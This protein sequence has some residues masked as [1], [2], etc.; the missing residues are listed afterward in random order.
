MIETVF[1]DDVSK[2]S[3][4]QVIKELRES[5]IRVKYSSL[6]R[7]F[8]K[9]AAIFAG[10]EK[11]LGEYVVI[12]DADLQDHPSL[13]IDMFKA[14]TVEGYDSAATRRINRYGEPKI[15]FI[16]ARLF[17]KIINK[18]SNKELVEGARDFRLMKRQMV[19]AIL[20]MRYSII[21][22]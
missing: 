16:F 5:D 20:E 18:I 12:M 6:S 11:S 9:E 8:G 13:L 22:H 2:D 4:L 19:N 17:Y 21:M 10:L 3:T 1:I 14:V 15:R 7:N